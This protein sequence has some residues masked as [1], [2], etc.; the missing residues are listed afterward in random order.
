MIG[1]D[2]SVTSIVK[3]VAH[4]TDEVLSRQAASRVGEQID[5][6]VSEFAGATQEISETVLRAAALAGQT[7]PG[8]AGATAH[9]LSLIHI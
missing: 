3:G 6:A 2:G 5:A 1:P 7:E 8:V 9:I 4:I